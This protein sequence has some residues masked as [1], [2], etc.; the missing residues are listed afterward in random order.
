M[1]SR[2]F[3]RSSSSMYTCT[4]CACGTGASLVTQSLSGGHGSSGLGPQEEELVGSPFVPHVSDELGGTFIVYVLH[5]GRCS[6][7][8]GN[9]NSHPVRA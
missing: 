7:H 3:T 9:W 8:M 4:A 1:F 5:S 6:A 2:L